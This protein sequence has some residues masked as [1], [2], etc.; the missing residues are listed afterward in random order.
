LDTV[1]DYF[2]EQT[3]GIAFSCRSYFHHAGR[4]DDTKHADSG[5]PVTTTTTTTI[6]AAAAAVCRQ[7]YQQGPRQESGSCMLLAVYYGVDSAPFRMGVEIRGRSPRCRIHMWLRTVGSVTVTQGLVSVRRC[8]VVRGGLGLFVRRV[9]RRRALYKCTPVRRFLHPIAYGLDRVVV[10]HPPPSSAAP[11]PGTM[12]PPHRREGDYDSHARQR[13]CRVAI[14]RGT[15][16]RLRH[17]ACPQCRWRYLSLLMIG[18]HLINIGT[19]EIVNIS[20]F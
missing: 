18:R 12:F 1:P 16:H 4:A 10:R 11:S 14:A 17:G 8:T 5:G 19:K 3:A 13:P 15:M 6:I 9:R 2:Y 20:I 7:R